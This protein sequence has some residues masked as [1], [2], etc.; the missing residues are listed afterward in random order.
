MS[1]KKKKKSEKTPAWIRTLDLFCM[2]VG[3]YMVV[4]G[5]LLYVFNWKSLSV[6]ALVANFYSVFMGM[7]VFARW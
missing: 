6:N 3:G 5:V 1:D 2:V 4:I 7:L